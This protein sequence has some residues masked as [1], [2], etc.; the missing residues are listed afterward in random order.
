MRAI[1]D[2]RLPLSNTTVRHIDL[3]L[4]CRACEAVCPSGVQYGELL[5]HTRDHSRRIIDAR[6]SNISPAHGH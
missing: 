4:G 3:C 5:E 2:G 6:R 1:Q